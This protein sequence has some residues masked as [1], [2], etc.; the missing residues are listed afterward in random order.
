MQFVHQWVQILFLFLIHTHT[1]FALVGLSCPYMV[2]LF[3]SEGRTHANTYFF[4]TC[5]TGVLKREEPFKTILLILLIFQDAQE[6]FPDCKT[7][8]ETKWDQAHYGSESF[9]VFITVLV[10][11]NFW[12]CKLTLAS[13]KTMADHVGTNDDNKSSDS[14]TPLPFEWPHL[15]IVLGA[16][17]GHRKS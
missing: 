7:S 8:N 9:S 5:K 13:S 4:K 6:F 1:V 2:S 11:C 16:G 14:L 17:M 12:C 10:W 15:V 3:L